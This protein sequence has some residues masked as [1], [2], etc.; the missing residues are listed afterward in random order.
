MSRVREAALGTSA[1]GS[2]TAA[3]PVH[4][5]T[6]GG[7]SD[8]V[9]LIEAQ[10][11]LNEHLRKTLGELVECLQT[12]RDDWS[13]AHKDL[14]HEMARLSALAGRRRTTSRAAVVRSKPSPAAARDRRTIASR[15]AGRTRQA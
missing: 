1:G 13:E 2:V 10:S 6:A 7:D 4:A 14:R 5:D 8:L 11:Q 3:P 9:K 12:L 15:R